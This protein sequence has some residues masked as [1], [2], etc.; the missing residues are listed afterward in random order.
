MLVR[1]GV[2]I[3]L[4]IVAL[5]SIAVS[6]TASAQNG[7]NANPGAS[8]TVGAAGATAMF[9]PAPGSSRAPVGHRQPRPADVPDDP[10]LSDDDR[11]LLRENGRVDKKLVICRGC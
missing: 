7:S 4:M 3:E 6:Q 11:A 2:V 8:T 10:E 1:H 9:Q 5:G